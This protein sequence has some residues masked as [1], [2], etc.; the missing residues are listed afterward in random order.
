M[1]TLEPEAERARPRLSARS[2]TIAGGVLMALW[3]S[4]WA[5]SYLHLGSWSFPV[6]L[7]IALLKAVVVVLFFME[8]LEAPASSAVA[9]LTAAALI[10]V[11]VTFTLLDI[12]TRAPEPASPAEAAHAAEHAP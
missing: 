9:V 3:A 10:A 7:S 4:S 12:H 6:A 2:A 11:L 8:L 5:L 1:S